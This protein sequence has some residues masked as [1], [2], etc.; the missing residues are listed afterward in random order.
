MPRPKSMENEG[1]NALP[2]EDSEG[3]EACFVE[4]ASKTHNPRH[5]RAHTS[6]CLMSTRM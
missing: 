2:G 6:T 4:C 5:V 3:G 1:R